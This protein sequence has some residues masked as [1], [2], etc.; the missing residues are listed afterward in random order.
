MERATDWRD[1][2]PSMLI[3]AVAILSSY[4]LPSG[5]REASPPLAFAVIFYFLR[6]STQP[7]MSVW[8]IV[9]AGCLLDIQQAMPIGVGISAAI[10]LYWLARLRNERKQEPNVAKNILCFMGVSAVT[11]AWI[12]AIMSLNQGQFYPIVA[13][14]MQWLMLV[15]SYPLIYGLCH[16]IHQQMNLN[17]S[18]SL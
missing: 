10:I 6:Q 16:A 18:R 2:L 9:L 11:M 17:Q 1:F 13:V 12:Y 3:I 14:I 4:I 5:L 7:L 15:I 8:V